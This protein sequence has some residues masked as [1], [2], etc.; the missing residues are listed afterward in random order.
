[1]N[2]IFDNQFDI[3]SKKL[4]EQGAMYCHNGKSICVLLFLLVWSQQ[5]W[6]QD[7]APPPQPSDPVI[8]GH[9]ASSVETREQQ[10]RLE[11]VT[12]FVND[13]RGAPVQLQEGQPGLPGGTGF[14]E[15][16]AGSTDI[17]AEE[18]PDGGRAITNAPTEISVEATEHRPDAISG[19][20]NGPTGISVEAEQRADGITGIADDLKGNPAE[21]GQRTDGVTSYDNGSTSNLAET[22][23]NEKSG[24][25]AELVDDPIMIPVAEEELKPGGVAGM[26]NGPTGISVEAE[27][28]RR[29]GGVSGDSEGPSKS[30]VTSSQQPSRSSNRGVLSTAPE[31]AHQTRQQLPAGL[32]ID[33]AD[34]SKDSA[35]Y[36]FKGG[37]WSLVDLP[38]PSHPAIPAPEVPGPALVVVT[39]EY[40]K[41]VY[42]QRGMSGLTNVTLHYRFFLTEGVAPN[43][44]PEL[45]VYQVV[46]NSPS[47]LAT[48]T[49]RGA[50][51]D[52][53][54]HLSESGPFTITFEGRL[55]MEGNEIAIDDVTISGISDGGRGLAEG[56]DALP[57]G[58][59]A[60]PP[61]AD[62]APVLDVEEGH[63]VNATDGNVPQKAN[64][65]LDTLESTQQGGGNP[66][67]LLTTVVNQETVPEVKVNSDVAPEF[68]EETEAT[69]QGI[70]STEAP[71]DVELLS[72]SG[73]MVE[74][75]GGADSQDGMTTVPVLIP[76]PVDSIPV[77]EELINTEN[78]TAALNS[79]PDSIAL[80]EEQGTVVSSLTP[81]A[82]Q[83][84]AENGTGDGEVISNGNETVLPTTESEMV[85]N[86]NETL[87][88][89]TN[90]QLVSEGNTTE[91]LLE[92][93]VDFDG[94]REPENNTSMINP[95]P[96]T[97]V[98][99]HPIPKEMPDLD[100]T[101]LATSGMTVSRENFTHS[102][103]HPVAS[104][105]IPQGTFA[106]HEANNVPN[107]SS[108]GTLEASG[109]PVV[110]RLPVSTTLET[111]PK[112][113]SAS[114]SG[115][116][117]ATAPEA[118]ETKPMA[119][120]PWGVFQVFLVLCLLGSVVLG[121][122][123]WR[124]KRRQDDEIPVFTRSSHADYHN[125]TFSP[126]D[127][128]SFAS[129][130][131][132]HSY[133]SFE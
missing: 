65:T 32:H 83:G 64:D 107:N 25:V 12:G 23:E 95:Q 120:T 28:E 111:F 72:P 45:K 46:G 100:K 56:K 41:K 38:D 7:E 68:P 40:L 78:E 89:T 104:E 58:E 101:T 112:T 79:L 35:H 20:V 82:E 114:P 126:D 113:S 110:S 123:Y 53:T 76:T 13:P 124:K 51:S 66:E 42:V 84:I 85:I 81:D 91:G 63:T 80:G 97:N 109:P 8:N 121:F 119:R 57:S 47:L 11:G 6:A 60:S 33:T 49:T 87:A 3:W 5:S 16:S 108:G 67:D 62:D 29:S 125:P 99:S 115:S 71:S 129:Y 127:D 17:R 90:S 4:I 24:G 43:G 69:A 92:T 128:S 39:R 96:S 34:W 2:L 36:N 74:A 93:T 130:G 77:D 103:T 118:S 52:R 88:S 133:K 10:V 44:V 122:L 30:L 75:T 1:M 31:E 54:V 86:E 105:E 117:N 14:P 98:S 61:D 102:P 116:I 37:E 131:A 27:E 18:A 94:T 48:E 50:W 106:T 9:T 21:A 15:N 55:N 132:R 59:A 73:G 22:E 70:N 19:F 26:V